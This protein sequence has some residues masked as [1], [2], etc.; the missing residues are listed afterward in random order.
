ML[1]SSDS[2][3]HVH[4]Y[5]RNISGRLNERIT[6]GSLVFPNRTQESLRF[7]E[8]VNKAQ[9]WKGNDLDLF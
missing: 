4:V 3:E 5:A 9:W 1:D 2:T 7:G 6:L 8:A